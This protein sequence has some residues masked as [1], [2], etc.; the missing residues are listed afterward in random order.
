VFASNFKSSSTN[1][2]PSVL[3]YVSLIASGMSLRF[4]RS[5]VAREI[6]GGVRAFSSNR[7]VYSIVAFSL[8]GIAEKSNKIIVFPSASLVNT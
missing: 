1:Q 5:I 3:V 6:S 2:L 8:G 7:M 4:V